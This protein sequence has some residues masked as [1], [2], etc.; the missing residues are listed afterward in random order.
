MVTAFQKTVNN[1]AFAL[2]QCISGLRK[3]W[4]QGTSL[5]II[6]LIFWTICKNIGLVTFIWLRVAVFW[7]ILDMAFY[8][9]FMFEPSAHSNDS[10]FTIKYNENMSYIYH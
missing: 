7:G 6:T 5:K 4:K 9:F 10:G 3:D 2:K 8:C 1:G